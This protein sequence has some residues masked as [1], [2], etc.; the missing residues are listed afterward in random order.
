MSNPSV[1]PSNAGLVININLIAG[2]YYSGGG[3]MAPSGG[4]F[5][6]GVASNGVLNGGQQQPQQIQQQ[7]MPMANT[8]PM[9]PNGQAINNGPNP[10]ADLGPAPTNGNLTDQMNWAYNNAISQRM[11]AEQARNHYITLA[12]QLNQQAQQ[13]VQ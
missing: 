1:L 6:N 5:A 4:P 2:A 9:G 12:N 3:T 10:F 7:S 8:V 13:Q 11:Q